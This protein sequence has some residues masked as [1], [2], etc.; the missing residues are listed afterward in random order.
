MT[1][2]NSSRPVSPKSAQR[3]NDIIVRIQDIARKHATADTSLEFN[4]VVQQCL[5]F[6]HHE[7]EDKHVTIKT[8]LEP[9]LPAVRGDRIQLQQVI[10]NL[11][12]N[13]IQAMKSAPE[14]RREIHLETSLDESNCVSFSIRDTGMGIPIKH[15]EQIF[16]GFF[17]T[18]EAGLGIGL[19]ICQSIINAHGGN[20]VAANH[21]DGGAIFRFSIPTQSAFAPLKFHSSA[22]D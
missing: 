21:P 1:R 8:S 17:T 16:D 4:D 6:L 13:S 5:A 22:I 18:K 7:S 12:V 9:K 19:A 3:A 11:M 10:V 20:I 2:S 14:T 15:M